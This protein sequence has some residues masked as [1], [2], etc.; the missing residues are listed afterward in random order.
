MG[1][2]ISAVIPISDLKYITQ[3]DI[4]VT[5]KLCSNVIT[6]LPGLAFGH[7]GYEAL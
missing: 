2:D 7:Y 3:S 4:V 5:S 6:V 1:K